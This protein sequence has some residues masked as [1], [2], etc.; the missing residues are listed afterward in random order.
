MSE[1]LATPES[2]TGV[3]KFW[4]TLKFPYL[5]VTDASLTRLARARVLATQAQY[6]GRTPERMQRATSSSRGMGEGSETVT[7]HSNHVF[8]QITVILAVDRR[9]GTP[10]PQLSRQARVSHGAAAQRCSAA[11]CRRHG[12]RQS[13]PPRRRRQPPRQPQRA[14]GRGGYLTRCLLCLMRCL[15]SSLQR[16]TAC[17]LPTRA[18]SGAARRAE[19]GGPSPRLRTAAL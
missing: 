16:S 12:Y 7:K 9:E 10:H 15:P 11:G 14:A 4:Q 18:S 3:T 1:H 8:F 17:C 19:C 6:L 13:C 5:R 2:G